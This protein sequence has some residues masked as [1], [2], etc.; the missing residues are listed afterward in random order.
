MVTHA[1]RRSAPATAPSIAFHPI[2]D[3][4]T[5]EIATLWLV[6]DGPTISL[7]DL[8]RRGAL[9]QALGRPRRDGAIRLAVRTMATDLADPELARDLSDL[10]SAW[11]LMPREIELRVH[12]A[13]DV[14]PELTRRADHLRTMGFGLT[15]VGFGRSA[16]ALMWLRA[17]PFDRV[18]IAATFSEN[19]GRSPRDKLMCAAV[20]DLGHRLGANVDA[21]GLSTEAQV[22]FARAVG[23]ERGHGRYWSV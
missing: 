3:L 23:A 12:P 18:E 4:T 11:G 19:L 16:G 7:R 15:L 21:A 13:H 2:V 6:T 22:S 20:V 17:I 1:S 14:G 8:I 9:E 10:V 5:E